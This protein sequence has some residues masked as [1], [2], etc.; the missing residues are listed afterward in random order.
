MLD[1]ENNQNFCVY[2]LALD[3]TVP[4]GARVLMV[5]PSIR[6]L[7]GVEDPY[8]FAGWFERI[9]P[10]DEQRILEGNIHALQLRKPYDE[11]VR[12]W[13]PG[14]QRWIW[15][16]TVSTPIFGPDGIPTHYNG[17]I[18]DISEQKQAEQR[19]Q[20]KIQFED[21]ITAISTQFINLPSIHIDE[22]IQRTLQSIGEFAGVDR[23]YVFLYSLDFETMHN[24]HEWCAAGIEP[25]APRLQNVPASAFEWFNRRLLLGEALH[26]PRVADLPEEAA[27]EE[28]EFS[29]QGIRSMIAVPLA[30]Q[31]QVN[32][33]LGF[34]SV[35]AEKTWDEEVIRLLTMVG[36][37]IV[38]ALEHKR[39]QQAI[40]QAYQLLEQRVEE[41]THELSTL[42]EVSHNLTSILD[43]EPLLGL[44]L[45]QLR[46]VVDYTGAAIVSVEGGRAS[47]QAY[48]GPIERETMLQK[49]FPE[50]DP[51]YH[52]VIGSREAVIVNDVQDL[53]GLGRGSASRTPRLQDLFG[54][55]HAWMGVPLI[56]QERVVG[57][58]ALDHT[59][60]GFYTA[61]HGRLAM[62]FASQA[63]VAIENARLY[64]EEQ[65]QRGELQ[66][67]YRAD[68][69]LYRHLQLNE[70]FEAL[71]DIAVEILHA[72]K[73]ILLVWD[74]NHQELVPAAARG[75]KSQTLQSLTLNEK[76]SLAGQVAQ[77]GQA[78]FV[79]NAQ[80]EPGVAGSIIAK[81]EISSFA[82]VPITI[83]GKVFGVFN[84]DYLCPR[85]FSME[86]RRL[87]IA[88]AQR[89]ALAI[90][91]AHLYREE[92]R[93]R[94]ETERRRQVA[95]GLR[96]LL[97]VLN[98]DRPIAEI[99]NYAVIQA[100]QLMG[101]T[102][103]MLRHADPE[104]GI[105]TTDASYNI[106]AEFNAIRVTRLYYS[107]N[108]YRLMAHQPI[109]IP[110]LRAEFTPLL[111]PGSALDEIQ[112]AGLMAELK[113]Y[114]SSL[115]V[116]VFI[117]DEIYGALRF[118]FE[119]PVEF[120]QEDI[121][122]AMAV[123]DQV[124]LAIENA[125]LRAHLQENAAAAER[126]RLARDLHDAVT[127]TLFSASLIAEVLPRLWE[128][129]PEEGRRRLEELRQLTRGALAEMRTLLLELRPAA[130]TEAPLDDLLRQLVEAFTGRT[131]LPV[132]LSMQGHCGPPSDVRVA[133]YRIAQEALN[134]IARHSKAQRVRVT[135]NCE[136]GDVRLLISDD[137]KGFDPAWVSSEHLGLSIM[138][139]RAQGIGAGLEIASQVGQGT[140][141]RV[142]WQ[143]PL[144]GEKEES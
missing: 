52:Q 19:L 27:A 94:H 33:F 86:D 42:L 47:V 6:Q 41:R 32:G 28:A 115:A 46:A 119:H 45:D 136:Q 90:E 8:N 131:R 26:I 76:D 1:L 5:S 123:G 99:L 22:G 101:S 120:T 68:E 79:Q 61:S 77:S 108:D 63:A 129:K 3:P 140:Q 62:A 126:N 88:L 116:P 141:V 40:N 89:A 23:S 12:V 82:H 74:A 65:Q 53:N 104:Q 113:Y 97:E 71:V 122:L 87:F 10:D 39:A 130:L 18:V 70:V 109:V 144:N 13:H 125:R 31:G 67:L 98:S 73:S 112:R 48:R 121:R 83:D 2:R 93:R 15:L 58:L 127:Q 36:E 128:R 43:L 142:H 38:N 4:F 134:N 50:D 96:S 85:A 110:D 21:L 124:A 75:F 106:P 118:Y 135:F 17:L 143:Q 9:H 139:E 92:Q 69:Q 14:K 64:T 25:Q 7:A 111:A 102:A 59:L 84:A 24:T 51:L 55:S 37:I 34:D 100:A 91:N 81:E 56:I 80:H 72:D 54:Y 103:S 78:L 49:S 133:L 132:D 66:A 57:L 117:R 60:P 29:T 35:R 30:Y 95:E 138:K 105:V 16:H 44:I 20:Y 114:R 107:S 137:G 11:V